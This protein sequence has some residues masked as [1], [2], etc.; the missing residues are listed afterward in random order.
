MIKKDI[1]YQAYDETDEEFKK[2]VRERYGVF[3][4][5]ISINDISCCRFTNKL[6]S[7]RARYYRD[8]GQWYVTIR[9]KDGVYQYKFLDGKYRDGVKECS[10]KEWE[11]SNKGYV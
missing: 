3:P 4:K 11:E 1:I 5:Y 2:R 6:D 10:E 7:K 9:I 8:G